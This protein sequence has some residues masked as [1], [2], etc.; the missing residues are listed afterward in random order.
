MSQGGPVI[1]SFPRPNASAEDPIVI[2]GIGLATSLGR[3]RE[4]VWKAIQK[5]DS[6]VRLTNENDPLGSLR[7]PCAMVDWLPAEAETLKSIQLSRHVA[8]EALEDASIPWQDVDPYRFGC[9]ISGQLGDMRYLYEPKESRDCAPQSS[10]WNQFLPCTATQIVASK[11]GLLGPRACHVVACASGL[12]STLAGMRMLQ[13]DQADFVLC[14]AADTVSELL[15]AAFHRIG[16]LAR[17]PNPEKACRPFDRERKGFVMGEGAALLVLEKR[18]QA[19]ARGAKVYAQL[20]ACQTL[21]QAYHMTG[22]DGD[23]ETLTELIK[24]VLRK[25]S[26]GRT[27]PQYINAHGTGTIQNDRSELVAIRAALGSLADETMISSNKSVMGHLINAAGSAELALTALALR[28]GYAPPTMH[29]ENPESI[30]GLDCLPQFGSQQPIDRA[31]K[32]SLAF[33]GH[34][35]GMALERCP[36]SEHQRPPLPLHPSARLRR[37]RALDNPRQLRVA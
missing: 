1:L 28:D 35:V 17:D 29:L 19:V 13:S 20:A 2:T 7:L 31:L 26:W 9:S 4:D 36:Q 21:C 10:W 14:G 27:G 23:A 11:F 8:G 22:L 5:G 25:S 34:L 18:S 30:G 24:Q 32:L 37:S 16:V 12:V 6:G 33:G 15:L 3:T